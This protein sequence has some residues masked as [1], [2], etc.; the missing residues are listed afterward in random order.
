MK[1]TTKIKE[2]NT[3]PNS[4]TSKDTHKTYKYQTHDR[5]NTKY[6]H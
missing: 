1:H 4:I 2:N 6:N 5:T 3:T